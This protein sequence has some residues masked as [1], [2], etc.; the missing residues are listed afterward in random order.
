MRTRGSAGASYYSAW[1]TST[2]SVRKN[3]VPKAPTTIT[4]SPSTY[5]T[6]NITLS[7]S[8]AS[9]GTSAI[10]GYMIASRTST[11]NSTWGAWDV[12][13]TMNLAASSGTY[14]PTVSR[15][16]GT[17]TQFG[18]WTIDK[19][20]VYSLENISNSILCA[21][22]AC[23]APTSFA[24]SATL[25]EGGVTLSWSGAAGGAGNAIIGYEIE[26][27]ESADNAAWGACESVGLVGSSVASGTLPVAPSGVRGNYKRF[28]I[29]VQGA[30]G[31]AYYS[32]WKTTTNTVRKN[33]LTTPP[34]TFSASPPI[35]ATSTITLNWSGTIAGISTIKNYVI[36]QSTSTN[37]TTWS[38]WEAVTTIVTSATS[39]TF[40]ATPS[41]ISGMFTR[42]DLSQTR[43]M[44]CQLCDY[45]VIKKNTSPP[46][47]TLPHQ[48]T[49]VLL[50]ILHLGISFKLV[51]KLT[52]N[53]R[54][55]MFLAHQAHG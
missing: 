1:K 36:Q 40:N 30:A 28:R 29:R 32:P 34:T 7:W 17:Y 42:P 37:N 44:R 49:A 13:I 19:L 9:G 35:Y 10:K 5:N 3:T 16:T 51:L 15:V 14:T 55:F 45:N 48:K 23:V 22:T 54:Q 20:D 38:T 50:T 43:L 4:A 26:S 8:G 33:V 11:N 39:G 52:A 25:S 6:E 27:S 46:A 2:N 18:I 53:R 31:S 41:A 12:L 47:L 21:V 24:L